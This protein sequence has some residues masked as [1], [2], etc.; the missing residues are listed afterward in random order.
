MAPP[1]RKETKVTTNNTT[2]DIVRPD[3]EWAEDCL[4]MLATTWDENNADEMQTVVEE[5]QSIAMFIIR[6][7]HQFV[8]VHEFLD[9]GGDPTRDD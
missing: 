6:Q 9:D 2:T 7:A 5:F 3:F 8:M 1:N 4:G